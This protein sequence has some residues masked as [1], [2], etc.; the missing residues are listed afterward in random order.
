MAPVFRT[1]L[2]ATDLEA[3]SDAA[4]A[5]AHEIARA[6]EG[7]LGVVVALPVLGRSVPVD[8]ARRRLE[9]QVR[10]VTDRDR[11]AFVA[12]VEEGHPATVILGV[13]KRLAADVIVVGRKAEHDEERIGSVAL[14]VVRDAPIPV[15][16]AREPVGPGPIVAA[17][18]LG[19]G[20]TEVVRIAA[21]LA[22][23]RKVALD[24]VHVI[25]FGQSD[26]LLALSSF[27]GGSMPPAADEDG[28]VALA[29]AALESELAATG[30]KG[31]A[32]IV[33]G[34]PKHEV[35]A[36]AARLGASALVVGATAHPLLTRLGLGSVAD[37]AVRGAA[38]SVLVVRQAAEV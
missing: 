16:V 2:A 27:F 30:A 22:R 17:V 15:I 13:A 24:V 34:E 33:K 4:I 31:E 25:D 38:T 11:D 29:R 12:Y 3:G 35:L 9:D 21:D 14:R 36:R 18:D 1:V 32:S 10:S 8:E 5:R 28:I 7:S 37:A 26:V 20:S 19:K 23:R 6:C